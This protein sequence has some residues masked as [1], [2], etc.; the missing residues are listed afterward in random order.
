MDE[1]HFLQLINEHQGI[2]H[3]ICKLYRESKEDREDLFQEIVFQLWKS[4]SSFNGKSKFS[5]WMYRVALS[6]AIAGFRKKK[7][8][9]IYVAAVPDKAADPPDANEQQ[10]LFWQ[11][12]AR[13]SD[14]DKAIIA[15]YLENLSY[16]EMADILG[17][18]ENNAGVKLN[19]AK[20]RLQ[21]LLKP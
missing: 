1:P 9:V 2:I 6:T 3:K 18:T 17:I 15:L 21:Q 11:A 14:D 20:T 10:Q 8:S 5:T 19:R 13:L 16:Q 12:L 7:P 4:V